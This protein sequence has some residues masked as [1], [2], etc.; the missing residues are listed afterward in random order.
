M[1]RVK[2]ISPL[3]AAIT[4]LFKSPEAQPI[5]S[6]ARRGTGF[7]PLGAALTCLAFASGPVSSQTV[8][9]TLP[10]VQV[11]GQAE[12]GE[13]AAGTS[14][15][16]AK[17]PTP[18]RDIPQ[19]VTV[20]PRAV[21]DAQGANTLQDALRYVPGITFSAGEGGN[22]GD[23][24]NLRG[25][26]ARTD[27][28]LDGFRDRSQYSRDTFFVESVEVLKGPSSLFFGRG[29]T[30]GVINQTTKQASL[31]PKNEVGV[32]VGTEDYYRATADF[33]RPLS[34]TSA[35]RISTLAHTNESTRD[36]I[37]A[38]RYG[39]APSFK[40]GIGTPTEVTLSS[41][42]Q[43][44]R[45]IPDYGFAV[46]PNGT[47]QNPGKPMR[48]DHDNF[49]G[50]TDDY[51]DQD[52]D[53]FT[54]RVEHIFSPTL[55]LRNQTQY[56]MT[57]VDARPTRVQ[58]IDPFL[59]RPLDREVDDNSLFNQ[60]D[61]IIKA[62][63][64]SIKH[65]FIAGVEIGRE[66][67]ERD[68]F[69]W[70]PQDFP[71][72]G[73][74]GNP[75]HE[76]LPGSGA[77]RLDDQISVDATTFAVYLNDNI[78]FTKQ[79][80]LAVGLRWDRYD[81]EQKTIDVDGDGGGQ[82][83]FGRVDKDLSGRIGLVYQPTETQSYYISYGTSFNPSAE[84]V[85]IGNNTLDDDGE[86]L[87]PEK[88]ES[89]EIGAKW[90]FLNGD[91]SVTTALFRIDK[92]DARTEDPITEEVEL[93]GSTRVDGFEIGFS[94][95]ITPAWQVFGGYT[96]LDGEVRDFFDGGESFDG[97][98]LQNTPEHSFSFWT[99][100]FLTPEWE[101]GGG[102]VYSSERVLNNANTAVTDGYTRYDATIAYHQKSYDIRLN[103][104]NLSDE[105]YFEVAS[106]G[107]AVPAKGRTALVTMA[108]RF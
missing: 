85:S 97:N 73:S 102:F 30:G 25:Q 64:G 103:V 9:T 82:D 104:L 107:R 17:V 49:Y 39:V 98:Q 15:V 12:G 6:V 55:K 1:K 79:W 52:V 38:E 24:I 99:S 14:T 84:T 77:R 93:Q 76:S 95:R 21:M 60:T 66:E 87:P 45:E 72:T 29:S 18:I 34:E 70:T 57:S 42:H 74:I 61:L 41:M 81:A 91:L 83:K 13:Y 47:K 32:T 58:S 90:D 11:K 108:Y 101:V 22:I 105:E 67:Y 8:G 78:E 31:A 40:F 16:G 88:N 100:Y 19:A 33:N 37:E 3:R 62:N 92:T 71:G 50:Y 75:V 28:F 56:S 26:S 80:K 53:V 69:G 51:F 36:V 44:N 7:V 68:S 23:N 96:Y 106:S 5:R 94:G 43:R 46:T 2:N 4:D 54:A 20:V 10:E 63:T 86:P 48:A 89:Y 65:T 35:F 59:K 27:V